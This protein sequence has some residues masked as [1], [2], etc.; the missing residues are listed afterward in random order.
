MKWLF[1]LIPLLSLASGVKTSD[2]IINDTNKEMLCVASYPSVYGEQEINGQK[3]NV[4]LEPKKEIIATLQPGEAFK[5]ERAGLLKCYNEL[6]KIES[7]EKNN[8]QR[9]NQYSLQ[10]HI[11]NHNKYDITQ[12]EGKDRDFVEKTFGIAQACSFYK[13][14]EYCN[15]GF[16]LDIIYDNKNKVQAILFYDNTLAR[17]MLPFE[18]ESILKLRSN[19]E[20]LGLWIV[21]NYKKLFSKKPSVQTKNL[22]MWENLSKHIKRVIMTPKRGH[23]ELSRTVK[24]G[25]NLFRDGRNDS[26]KAQE[27]IQAIEIHYQ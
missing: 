16:G 15:H 6:S 9:T 25:R 26:E 5:K 12:Y 24:N 19:T 18:P 1:L 21:Q 7:F 17:G 23:F 20:P 13:D 2:T 22:I 14:G 3:R 8:I 11:N 10:S 4:E 27:Y